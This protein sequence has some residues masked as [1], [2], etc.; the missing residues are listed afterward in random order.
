MELEDAQRLHRGFWEVGWH[1]RVG[2]W[3]DSC[4]LEEE[5]NGLGRD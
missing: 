1:R 5:V 2:G 4:P 3:L